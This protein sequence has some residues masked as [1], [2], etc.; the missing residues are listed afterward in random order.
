MYN[1]GN[2]VILKSGGPIMTVLSA[3]DEAEMIDDDGYVRVMNI[4]SCSWFNGDELCKGVFKIEALAA[5]DMQTMTDDKITVLRGALEVARDKYLSN[6][7]E[8]R[9]MHG[10]EKL[11]EQFD[12]QAAD[13]EKLL[14]E[15]DY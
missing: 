13:A 2:L 1:I 11:A 3:A 7:A 9:T 6:A 12:R 15:I 8:L 4:V 10:H 14:E 5:A